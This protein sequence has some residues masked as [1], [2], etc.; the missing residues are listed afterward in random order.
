VRPD[1]NNPEI[2]DLQSEMQPDGISSIDR[3]GTIRLRPFLTTAKHSIRINR[4]SHSKATE[5]RKMDMKQQD[6]PIDNVNS[7]CQSG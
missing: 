6:E 4:E 5:I 7:D 2:N 3:E 1:S